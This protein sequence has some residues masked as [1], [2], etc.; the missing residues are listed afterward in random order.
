MI[1]IGLYEFYII[2]SI[3]IIPNKISPYLSATILLMIMGFLYYQSYLLFVDYKKEY[4]VKDKK[5]LVFKI[6]GIKESDR[7]FYRNFEY[8]NKIGFPYS[9]RWK[10]ASKI[11][12]EY[13]INNDIELYSIPIETNDI[14]Y[15]IQFYTNRDFTS[16]G[17]RFVLAVKYPMSLVNDYKNFSRAKDKTLLEKIQSR[18][19]DTLILL[20]ITDN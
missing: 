12:R 2:V 6:K 13:E 9:R 19:G 14:T 7:K 16:T 11:M 20:Y 18:Y 8:N 4:P 17:K 15:P 3:K 10:Q 5:L 1:G